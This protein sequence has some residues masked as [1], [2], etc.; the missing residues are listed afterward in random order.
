MPDTTEPESG[1]TALV[2]RRTRR[3]G[4][5]DMSAVLFAAMSLMATAVAAMAQEEGEGDP[6]PFPT[7]EFAEGAKSA[8]V[9][10]GNVT[11]GVSQ[12]LRPEID[13]NGEVPI[14]DVMV[15]GKSVLTVP[16]VF[17]GFDFVAA[18]ASIAD[19]DP[20]NAYPEIYF[21]S[22][23]G[24]AHCCNSVV[25]AEEVGGQWV[26]VTVGEFD[27]DGNYLDDADR[28]GLAEIVTADNRFLYAFDC[29]ACSAAPLTINTLRGGKVFDV[30]ADP[31]YLPA[32]RDWLD[33]LEANVE[34]EQRWT[35]P[36]YLA[37]WVA[38]KIRVGE[39]DDAW[40]QLSANWNYATDAGEEVCLTGGE[41][42]DCIEKSR[43]VLKFPERLK[44][45]LK[46]AGYV[47]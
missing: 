11:A 9:T 7:T 2:H 43:A 8:A 30:S 13:P 24:G 35:S 42:D 10:V 6:V 17:S 3:R 25:V 26:G 5:G 33:Q 36:G 28:D 16:G 18:E 32:H 39:G 41:V 40:R 27:G 47:F 44:L 20:A 38:A 23:S 4:S 37:G 15:D 22:Y 34:P 14:L 12:A 29:Y 31:R 21:S 45:F 46:Q 1:L 19:M